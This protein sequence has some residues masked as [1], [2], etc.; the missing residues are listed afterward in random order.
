MNN[1]FLS[2]TYIV[3]MGFGFPLMRFISL[4]FDVL[5]NNAVRFLAGA[6]VL[7]LGLMIFRRKDLQSLLKKP[8]DVGLVVFIASL[9][10][11][12]MFFFIK[13]LALTTALSASVFA[14]ISM[15]LGIMVAALFFKDERQK[16]RQPRFIV[17]SLIA[18]AGALAFILLTP[19]ANDASQDF[20][21]GSLFLTFA[22]SIQAVQNLFIK[23]FTKRQPTI[24]ISAGV[25]FVAGLIF[26]GFA[27]A[28][29]DIFSLKNESI[30]WLAALIGTGIY[31]ILAGMLFAFYIIGH[32]GIVVF[33]V[34][35]LM[36]PFVTAI[37][38]YLFL[39]ENIQPLQLVAVG[40]AVFGCAV[41]IRAKKPA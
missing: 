11:A 30:D 31:G 4:H 8:A 36:I 38:S 2:L 14:L 17:G 24:V 12:N 5:T 34:L 6:S 20:L 7:I 19:Q 18:L 25:S 41:A 9:M 22:I 10:T 33:N 27:F 13:G 39:G 37:I 40:V 1:L 23:Q 35:G 3:L 26:L 21:L 16:A 32:L 15:P 29:G 28:S